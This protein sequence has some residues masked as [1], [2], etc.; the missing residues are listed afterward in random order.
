MKNR[1]VMPAGSLALAVLTALSGPAGAED[2][3]ETPVIVEMAIGNPDARVEVIEYASLTC[4][5]CAT[6][7]RDVFPRLKRDYID[8][9]KINFILREVYF[10]RP[11]LFASI[12]A[13]CGGKDRFFPIV[14]RI[15]ATQQE[16]SRLES[17]PAIV[18]RLRSIALSMGVT[19]E[20]FR[21]CFYDQAKAELLVETEARNKREHGI[22]STPSFVINGTTHSNMSYDEFA[23]RIDAA[24]N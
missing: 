16:W 15:L 10:D 24:L 2:A 12:T 9:G 8:T 19:D 7:H 14:D 3:A 18:Q 21:T 11:G 5:H 4:P 1:W 20:A 23:S 13:R 6:F 17:Q 22:G